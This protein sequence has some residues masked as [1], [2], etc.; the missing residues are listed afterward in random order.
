MPFISKTPTPREICY[1]HYMI[2]MCKVERAY[3]RPDI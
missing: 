1:S 3:G 2:R